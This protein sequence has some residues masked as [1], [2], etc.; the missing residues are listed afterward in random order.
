M[1]V[2]DKEFVVRF[3]LRA[4]FPDDYEGDEDGYAWAASF[5]PV[6]Q[7]IVTAVARALAGHP[8]W[9][10][11]PGNRGRSSEDEVTFILERTI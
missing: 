3:E 1:H 9:K 2:E 5:R 10:I 6:A 7:G 4:A 8:G 11:R